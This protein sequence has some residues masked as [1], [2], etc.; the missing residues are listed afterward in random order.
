MKHVTLPFLCATAALFAAPL[1]HAAPLTPNSG[2]LTVAG[3]VTD[4]D[5]N[6]GTFTV[7][8]VL[9]DGHFTGTASFAIAGTSIAGPLLEQRSYLENGRCYF[10]MENG[11]TR[12]EFS[13][14]CDST[15]MEGRFESFAG[16]DLKNGAAKAVF[17]LAG[18]APVAETSGSLP[19][20]KLTCAYNEPK[21]G[22]RLGE[23]TQYS[24]RFSN[25]ASLTL[26]P[27]GTYTTGN[28]GRGRFTREPGGKIRLGAGP[29]QGA[30]G[31]L[32]NDRSGAP[33]VV[34]HI[35]ENRRPDGVHLVDPYTTHCTRAR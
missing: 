28:G 19:S 25:L 23:T 6:A 35:E 1:A 7:Q 26:D 16:G 4:R 5:N 17:T 24:L 27:A 21:I 29:W 18:G 12:A 31:T 32:E 34:F 8:A 13:G 14:K 33:A 10:R 22:V 30:L 15:G 3:T 2:A 9:K 20:G 11:R